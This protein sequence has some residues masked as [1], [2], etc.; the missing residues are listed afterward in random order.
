[1]FCSLLGLMIWSC[2][3]FRGYHTQQGQQVQKRGC[4]SRKIPRSI[5]R[6]GKRTGGYTVG[7]ITSILLEGSCYCEG[8]RETKE[9]SMQPTEGSMSGHLLAWPPLCV[10]LPQCNSTTQSVWTPFLPYCHSVPPSGSGWYKWDTSWK[11]EQDVT[12]KGENVLRSP[13]LSQ[14]M[15]AVQ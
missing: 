3:D 1:M 6:P 10:W 15:T 9:Q 8:S 7:A 14:C 5:Y 13:V 11:S 4:I 2:W 12:E